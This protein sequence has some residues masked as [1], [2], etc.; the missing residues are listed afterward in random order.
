VS[1]PNPRELLPVSIQLG[2]TSYSIHMKDT[3]MDRFVVLTRR[4][5]DG[6]TKAIPFPTDLLVVFAVQWSVARVRIAFE[7]IVAEVFS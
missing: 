3:D 6:T 2:G 5:R 7:R 1:D 4:E